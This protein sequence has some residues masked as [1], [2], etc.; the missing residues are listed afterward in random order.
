MSKK[1]FEEFL[2]VIALLTLC[3]GLLGA[4]G[5]IILGLITSEWNGP[6]L[7]GCIALMGA[8]RFVAGLLDMRSGGGPDGG[9]T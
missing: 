8:S 9:V 1:Q 6:A 2:R 5:V 7:A 4:T 3:I